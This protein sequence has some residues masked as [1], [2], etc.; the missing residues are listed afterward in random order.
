LNKTTANIGGNQSIFFRIAPATSQNFSIHLR[1]LR[2]VYHK[3]YSIVKFNRIE[4]GAFFSL[5]KKKKKKETI[6]SHEQQQRAEQQTS[7]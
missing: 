3:P 7:R 4:L 2:K 6:E 1:W 5:R